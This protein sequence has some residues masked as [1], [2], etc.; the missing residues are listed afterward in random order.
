MA[1]LRTTQEL[2]EALSQYPDDDEWCVKAYMRHP[3][4]VGKGF[5]DDASPITVTPDYDLL[6]GLSN[7]AIAVVTH[8]PGRRVGRHGYRVLRPFPRGSEKLAEWAF[9]RLM[10]EVVP[11]AGNGRLLVWDPVTGRR[12]PAQVAL[13]P[14]GHTVADGR[15]IGNVI[16]YVPAVVRNRLCR[17]YGRW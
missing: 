12:V 15:R 5:L 7:E 10:Y 17:F 14:R 4:Q 9:V 6:V 11:E 16:V 1:L 8:M 2:V 13:N 3:Y